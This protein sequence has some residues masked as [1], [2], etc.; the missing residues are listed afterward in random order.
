M[1]VRKNRHQYPGNGMGFGTAVLLAAVFL[2]VVGFVLATLDA[3]VG[4]IGWWV[5]LLLAVG[6]YAWDKFKED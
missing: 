5:V 3:L 1:T 6:C 4:A 2:V